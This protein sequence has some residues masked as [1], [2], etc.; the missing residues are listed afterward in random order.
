LVRLA[1][2]PL[3]RLYGS[4]N[5]SAFGPLALKTVR[6][7]MIEGGSCRKTI[8]KHV[9]RIKQM[10][11]WAVENELAPQSLYHG[12]QAV[13]G[14]QKGRTEARETE[15]V[16][17]VPAEFVEAVLPHVAPQV[18]AMIQLQLLT[19]MRPGEVCQMRG[20]DLSTAGRVWI[21]RPAHHKNAWR[22]KSREIFLGPKAQ[23][24]LQPWLRLDTEAYLFSPAEARAWQHAMMRRGRRSKVQPSQVCRKNK[25]PRRAP[26][27]HYD[28]ASYRRAITYACQKADRLAH[29]YKPDVA[30]DQVLVPVWHPNQLRH[31]AATNLRKQYGI[32]L[33]RIILGHS[34]AFTTEIYAEQDHEAAQK[35]VA[36][37]G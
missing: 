30:A 34:T 36:K 28:T 32:E 26:R 2:R 20:A 33:A 31:N 11:R 24:I 29:K 6:Q 12:L 27:S 7:A 21:Y 14:L 5:A 8:N 37:I 19:G 4:T 1:L 15:P 25:K 22:E 3:R 17:P 13:S 10:F 16:K 23:G 9:G 35:I 18:A